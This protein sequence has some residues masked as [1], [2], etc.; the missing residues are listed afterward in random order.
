MTTLFTPNTPVVYSYNGANYD[1][2]FIGVTEA[3][4]TTAPT[5]AAVTS[6]SYHSGL[7]NVALHGRLGTGGHQQRRPCGL[8]GHFHPVGRRADDAALVMGLVA[9]G[10][11]PRPD[12]DRRLGIV[13]NRLIWRS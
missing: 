13:A 1:I 3:S 10:W 4:S 7:V 12:F 5:Y 8:A 9:A 2:D 11:T 6:R